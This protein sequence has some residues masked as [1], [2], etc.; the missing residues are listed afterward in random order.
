MD[1]FCKRKFSKKYFKYVVVILLQLLVIN[2][3]SAL[4]IIKGVS[5]SEDTLP[6]DKMAILDVRSINK[7][8]AYPTIN[9]EH[10]DSIRPVVNSE[11]SELLDGLMFYVDSANIALRWEDNDYTKE[12]DLR[13]FYY[14][15]HKL[16]DWQ[17]IKPV[18]IVYP[19][20]SI[21]MYSGPIQ[22]VFD[23]SGI[24][25]G[26][27]Q[28][29]H[30]CNG[31][32]GTPDLR[33]RFV[34]GADALDE[35]YIVLGESAGVN[36]VNTERYF[37]THKHT[38]N[39]SMITTS[40]IDIEEVGNHTHDYEFST[41]I[42]HKHKYEVTKDESA[43]RH[44]LRAQRDSKWTGRWWK[45]KITKTPQV[46]DLYTEQFV[47]TFEVPESPNVMTAT[48]ASGTFEQHTNDSIQPLDNRPQ[49]YVVA[50]I[51]RYKM[52]NDV[53]P[54]TYQTTNIS[55]IDA[56]NVPHDDE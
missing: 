39:N 49:Y 9:Y 27:Y 41:P 26:E 29:W 25:S 23:S 7:G 15:D 42:Q 3:I 22:G 51:M 40:T 30:I 5:I 44:A 12:E 46:K 38:V 35:D 16:G 54:A 47:E 53:I 48:L 36:K 52:G 28:E 2:R 14:W 31:K 21:I 19:L 56:L 24:G 1:R 18:E 6:P 4:D 11:E 37:P 45:P 50:Y 34:V 32:H 17:K 33:G 20:G 13:G 43:G 55:N 10:L 8:V